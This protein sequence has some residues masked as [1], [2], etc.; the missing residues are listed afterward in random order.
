M[1][2][3]RGLAAQ[4]PQLELAT[5]LTRIELGYRAA[6]AIEIQHVSPTAVGHLADVAVRIAR[7]RR[8]AAARQRPAPVGIIYLLHFSE[9][10]KHAKHYTGWTADLSARLAKHAAGE[11]ARLLEV[12]GQAGI[13]WELAR[14]WEGPR[15]RERQLKQHGASRRCP[16]CKAGAQ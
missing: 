9:P 7:T 4:L 10:Y 15:S 2:R 12:V 5:E 8:A 11:G 14:T 16:L 13:S 1:S 3:A 6:M